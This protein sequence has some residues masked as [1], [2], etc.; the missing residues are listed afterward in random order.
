MCM[1]LA[2]KQAPL[3]WTQDPDAHT[4]AGKA[5]AFHLLIIFIQDCKDLVINHVQSSIKRGLQNDDPVIHSHALRRQKAL[6]SWEKTMFAL[7]WNSGNLRKGATYGELMTILNDDPDGPVTHLNHAQ[8]SWTY[9]MLAK[10]FFKIGS[11]DTPTAS[12]P[13]TIRGSFI[14]ALP[15]AF[16]HIRT[17]C[18]SPDQADTWI[19]RLL[20]GMM[21]S[22]HIHFIPWKKDTKGARAVQT[23]YWMIIKQATGE[24]AKKTPLPQTIE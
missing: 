18:R 6:K 20:A 19:I 9:E 10:H 7:A 23:Q 5:I 17:H 21:K 16:K 14:N 22:L 4:Y 3:E 1:M 12:A 13:I 8:E 15:V 11:S 24:V 2:T